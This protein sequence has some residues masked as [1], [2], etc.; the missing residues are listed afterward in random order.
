M[1]LLLR[2]DQTQKQT[3]KTYFCLLIYKNYTRRLFVAYPV[4]K[5]LSTL[6]RHGHLPREDDGAIEFWRRKGVSS[7]RFCAISTLVWWKV[8]VYNGERRRKQEHILI[9]YWS[10]R[11][12]NSLSPSSSRSFRTLFHWSFI[13]GQCVNSEQFLRVHLSHRMCS[14]LTLHHEFRIDTGR[15]NLIKRQ[16]V[17]FTI[18]DPMNKEYRD[19]DK[20]DLDAPHLARYHHKKV[21]NT[22]KHGVL[23]R[24]Q[25]CSQ[26]RI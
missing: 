25:T 6:L 19:L 15:T 14:Q 17:F 12:R 4:S 24:H 21:E 11:T 10:I 8:E 1:Y 20:I 3:M 9:L 5:R 13:T 2:A 22:S 18:V 26:E 16:T 23:G 7:D